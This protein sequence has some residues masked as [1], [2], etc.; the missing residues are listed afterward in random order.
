MGR[1]SVKKRLTKSLGRSRDAKTARK[2]LRIRATEAMAELTN[3]STDRHSGIQRLES[4]ESIEYFEIPQ[5]SKAGFL[6]GYT[7]SRTLAP[8]MIAPW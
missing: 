7:F 5:E 8:A 2:R 3:T 1:G 6:L 4:I